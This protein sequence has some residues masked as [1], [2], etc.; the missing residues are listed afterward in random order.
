MRLAICPAL[1]RLAFYPAL[2][3][4]HLICGCMVIV[5]PED[6]DAY[7]EGPAGSRG[8]ALLEG[9]VEGKSISLEP[10]GGQFLLHP[11]GGWEEEH[12]FEDGGWIFAFGRG[13]M[14]KG[15]TR[16]TELGLLHLPY[17]SAGQSDWICAGAGSEMSNYG[18]A[19]HE[20]SLADLSKMGSCSDAPAGQLTA[21]VEFNE[22][23]S[24]SADGSEQLN[25]TGAQVWGVS[26]G[27]VCAFSL[28]IDDK[29]AVLWVKPSVAAGRINTTVPVDDAS[30]ILPDPDGDYILACGGPDST[31][32][33]TQ[34]FHERVDLTDVSI[35]GKCPGD[36]VSGQVL[37][38][39]LYPEE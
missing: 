27:E 19:G 22:D 34:A 24:S 29:R 8:P 4:V 21:S 39:L 17:G 32:T 14:R 3:T 5:G 10:I 20:I 28:T 37:S 36:P 1:M 23:G 11:E 15:V 35:V 31:I 6:E 30:L 7:D 12:R 38:R 18:T 16:S 33:S 13:E 2:L 9:E 25:L 26:C